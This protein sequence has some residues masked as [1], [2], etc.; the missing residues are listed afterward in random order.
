MLKSPE[1]MYAE[2]MELFFSQLE[3]ANLDLTQPSA[4]MCGEGCVCVGRYDVIEDSTDELFECVAKTLIRD[5]SKEDLL[6]VE[7]LIDDRRKELERW[8]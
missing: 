5:A 1:Q 4:F 7:K 2:A 3:V 6:Y 8:C